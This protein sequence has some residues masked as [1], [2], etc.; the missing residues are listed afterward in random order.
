MIRVRDFAGRDF[1]DVV[2]R[3]HATNRSAYAYV[4]EHRAH[5]LD[6]ARNFIRDHVLPRCR[7][8]VATR[9]QRRVGLLAL[10]GDWIRQF[11][12]FAPHRRQGIGSA[13][14]SRARELSPARLCLYTFARNTAARAFY[15]HHG[16][17][18]VAFGVSPAPELEPDIEYRWTA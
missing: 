10:D 2:A 5:T 18:A 12:V 9:S 13:L 16:F 14:L 3:W 17:V 8:L 1:D 6:D 4:A 7:V 11:A 15:E